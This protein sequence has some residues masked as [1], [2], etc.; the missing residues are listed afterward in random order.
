MLLSGQ[1][2]EVSL[3]IKYILKSK[4][5]VVKEFLLELN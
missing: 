1:F 5:F 3:R 2:L 4:H